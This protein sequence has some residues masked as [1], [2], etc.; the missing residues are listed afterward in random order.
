M[1]NKEG[2]SNPFPTMDAKY[3]KKNSNYN[4]GTPAD[5]GVK[6][7]WK[8]F[9]NKPADAGVADYWSNTTPADQGVT[10]YW[11]NQN[12]IVNTTTPMKGLKDMPFGSQERIDEYN[13]RDWAMDHTTHPE[14]E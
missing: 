10:D 9:T 3:S 6:E 13:R 1:A 11:A 12:K 7:Y 2:Q 4:A 14:D 5:A 8:S